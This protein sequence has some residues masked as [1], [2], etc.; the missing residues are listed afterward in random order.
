MAGE[1]KP[2][3]E[4]LKNGVE[5]LSA[6]QLA[7]H[8]GVLYAGYVK[9]LAEIEAKLATADLTEANATY[10]FVGE[11]KREESF[12]TNAVTLHEA[13]FDSLGGDGK[14]SGRLAEMIARDFGSVERWDADFR[15]AGLAARGWVVL[16]FNWNDMRL[17]DYSLDIHTHGAWG[18]SPILVLDVYE[19]AYFLDYGTARKKYIDAF[20]RNADWAA[21]NARAEKCG[22]YG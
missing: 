6:R 4:K 21:A 15:A 12:C 11:L 5:G 2:L 19:H 13:Y 22:I 3:K 1:A 16:A 7:E 14:P 18:A 8:H 10:S 20:M 9:K 17:H